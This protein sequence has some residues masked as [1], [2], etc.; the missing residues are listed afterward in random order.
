MDFDEFG[1]EVVGV[2]WADGDLVFF[3]SFLEAG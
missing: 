1:F 2:E 3:E